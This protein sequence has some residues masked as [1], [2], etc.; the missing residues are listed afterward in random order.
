VFAN[1]LGSCH[2]QVILG[3]SW[4]RH[5]N[6]NIDWNTGNLLFNRC[7]SQ[8]GNHQQWEE[9]ANARTGLQSHGRQTHLRI[10]MPIWSRRSTML[11]SNL[12]QHYVTRDFQGG[13]G[14]WKRDQHSHFFFVDLADPPPTKYSMFSEFQYIFF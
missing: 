14:T 9:E 2:D 12:V 8:C 11:R 3:Y 1:G 5:H 4:L 13:G 7:P 6:P 10:T